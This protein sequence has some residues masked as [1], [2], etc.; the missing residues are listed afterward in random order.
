MDGWMDFL[1][2]F[3][4]VSALCQT[5]FGIISKVTRQSLPCHFPDSQTNHHKAKRPRLILDAAFKRPNLAFSEETT[6]QM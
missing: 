4:Y 5:S 3:L 2:L 6:Y 1:A